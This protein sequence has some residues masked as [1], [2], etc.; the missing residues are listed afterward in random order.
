MID[1]WLLIDV[2]NLTHK[3]FHTI[4]V[5][6]FK[7]DPTSVLFG[8]F[9]EVLRL[10]KRFDTD[11]I[12]FAFDGGHG[13]RLEVFPSYKWRRQEVWQEMTD[14]ERELRRTLRSQEK[15]LRVELLPNAGFK[16][17]FWEKGFEA[18]DMI[19]SVCENTRKPTRIIIVSNDEDFY[20]LI[21]PRVK[22]FTKKLGLVGVKWFRET[23]GIS[24]SQW[25]DVKALSGCSSDDIPG[26]H[27]VGNKT[28]SM[29]L[30]G[31]LP[32]KGKLFQSI[33]ACGSQ[34]WERNIQL[35]KLPLKGTP[36]Q[37]LVNDGFDEEKWDRVM[38]SLGMSTLSLKP[39]GKGRERKT[40]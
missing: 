17:I 18:D 12:A 7:D 2:S 22:I 34:I 28:A 15:R 31:T 16:N 8:F 4:P 14:N 20:Q 6:Y 33:A 10:R 9:Q 21:S 11:K 38:Q 37:R 5:L 3:Y 13:K 24:P 35:T 23:W 40:R 30:A 32:V 29:F 25:A 19:A 1:K 39:I 36:K 27:Q 26:I